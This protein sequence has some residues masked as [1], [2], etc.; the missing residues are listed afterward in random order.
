MNTINRCLKSIKDPVDPKCH[1]GVYMVPCSCG[2]SYIGETS[3]SIHTRIQE[4]VTNIKHNRSKTWA[5]AEHS[6]KT[7]HHVCIEN[8]RVVAKIDHYHH[9]KLREAIEI[10]KHPNNLNRD[11]GLWPCNVL[12]IWTSLFRW[13]KIWERDGGSG[14]ADMRVLS[15]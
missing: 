5:L 15:S 9:R 2:K 8:Y 12:W 7:K 13:G 11:E 14:F 4:H 3:R 10:G 1:K 6:N